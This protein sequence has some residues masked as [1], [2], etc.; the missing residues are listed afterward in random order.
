MWTNQT[1]PPAE[2]FIPGQKRFCLDFTLGTFPR[3]VLSRTERF[4]LTERCL[5]HARNFSENI[6]RPT[7][8][9]PQKNAEKKEALREERSASG[10]PESKN[11][12]QNF[13]LTPA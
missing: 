10:K 3:M 9:R 12:D 4:F 2:G 1:G 13:K 6:F 11:R 8:D 7:R 5:S